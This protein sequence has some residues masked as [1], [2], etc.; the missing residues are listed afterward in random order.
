LELSTLN[1]IT[2]CEDP[3]HRC[4]LMIGHVGH[5]Q[6]W[7]PQ[8]IYHAAVKLAALTSHHVPLIY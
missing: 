6:L 1:L 7:D 4:H 2:L 3:A 8:V 5:W